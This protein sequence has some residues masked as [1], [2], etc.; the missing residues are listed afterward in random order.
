VE[1]VTV[2][3]R[4]HW[5]TLACALA[6]PAHLASGQIPGDSVEY[7]VKSAFLLNFTKFVEWPAGSFAAPDSPLGICILGRDPFGR[8]LDETVQGEEV[9][10]RK[11]VVHRLSQ[12]PAPKL[13][14][15]VFVGDVGKDVPKTIS[16]LGREVLTV[17]EGEKFLRDGGIIAFVIQ[18]RHVRFD[19]NQ[20]AAEKSNLKLSSKLL[21]VA[22][23]VE[24]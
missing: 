7:Q 2:F 1:K 14:Q 19:I 5:L 20:K 18:D 8:A 10:S 9:N 11:L 16:A 22:R 21:N 15:V 3:H 13:C 6:A 4:I 23:A 17:G 24:K 12:L